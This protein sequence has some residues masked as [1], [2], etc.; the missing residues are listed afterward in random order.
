MAA[1]ADTSLVD[2]LL[3]EQLD[4]NPD[5]ARLYRM[6]AVFHQAVDRLR[7]TLYAVAEN[8]RLAGIPAWTAEKVIQGTLDWH[9]DDVEYRRTDAEYVLGR[10]LTADPSLV[11][12]LNAGL[13]R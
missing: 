8:M 1:P 2:R 3:A 13:G 11:A 9:I 7:L 4:E 10:M 5:T 12:R 6:D